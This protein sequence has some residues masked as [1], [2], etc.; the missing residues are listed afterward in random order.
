VYAEVDCSPVDFYGQGDS[1]VRA[2]L[3]QHESWDVEYGFWTGIAGGQGNIVLPH[4]ASDAQILDTG[5][6][7]II[8]QMAATTVTGV[9]LSPPCALGLLESALVN[10]LNGAGIIHVPVSV[11]PVLAAHNLI[12]RDGTRL[13]T[14][15][16]NLIAAGAGYPGTGPDGAASPINTAWVYGTGP[17]FGYR[18]D[19]VINSP[20]QSIDTSINDVRLIAERTYV[21]GFDCCLFAA[22][23]CTE[24]ES[25]G[26]TTP[27]VPE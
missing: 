26:S 20:A 2:A 1:L 23:V 8:L 24:C 5:V 17:I 18:G 22:L 11:I 9:G 7:P 15:N 12:Y 6:H 3:T 10:C 14:H 25:C 27:E 13:K 19:V 16:G 21:L 4:L